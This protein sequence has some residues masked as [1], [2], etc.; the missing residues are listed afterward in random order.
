MAS[1]G[2]VIVIEYLFFNAFLGLVALIVAIFCIQ[3]LEQ[4]KKVISIALIA[5]AL[6]FPWDFFAISIKAWGHVDPGPRLLGVPINDLILIFF[7]TSI[8]ASLLI[9]RF[10]QIVE[11]TNRQAETEHGDEKT[12]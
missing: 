3:S 10:S 6:G 8:T 1:R 9:A 7:M 5:V 11:S 4:L 12:S 2:A